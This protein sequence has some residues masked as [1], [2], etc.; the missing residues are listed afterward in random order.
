MPSRELWNNQE[1]GRKHGSLSFANGEVKL[2]GDPQWGGGDGAQDWAPSWAVVTGLSLESGDCSK[3]L[4]K[5]L[6]FPLSL[7]SC[8]SGGNLPASQGCRE[9]PAGQSAVQGARHC[10]LLA[11]GHT[12]RP[13]TTSQQKRKLMLR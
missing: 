4:S 10:H 9:D 12:G 3:P 5:C 7:P 2:W 13:E 11:A 6:N 1:A 8:S